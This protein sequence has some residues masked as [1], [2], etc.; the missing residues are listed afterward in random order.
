MPPSPRRRR[1]VRDNATARRLILDGAAQLFMEQGFHATSVREIGDQLGISQSSLYYHARNKPQILIDLNDEFMNEL[2]EAIEAIAARDDEPVAR[3]RAVI[4]ELLN[5]I[6]RHQAV[7]TVVLHERRSLPK[8]AA[9]AV[10]AQRDRIDAIIDG[11]IEEGIAADQIV[12]H[13]PG[14]IRLALTGMTNWAYTWYDP[15]GSLSADAIADS[16]ASFLLDGI[17]PRP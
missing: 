4:R 15:G 10:Q 6:A 1:V 2:V 3:L 5:V 16:F 9:K 14:L 17:R 11:I 13:P 8:G 12:D 7:V